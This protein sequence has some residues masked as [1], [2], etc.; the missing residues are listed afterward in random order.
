MQYSCSIV[1]TMIKFSFKKIL[2]FLTPNNKYVCHRRPALFINQLGFHSNYLYVI[3][4]FLDFCC[5]N[6][7]KSCDN[8]DIFI[9][10]LREVLFVAG[11]TK[12]ELE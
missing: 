3:E 9:A 11:V 6:V 1:L 10:W 5:V 12:I 2:L 8:N 7:S 4:N